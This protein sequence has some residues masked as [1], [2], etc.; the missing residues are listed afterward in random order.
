MREEY[1]RKEGGNEREMW[2]GRMKKDHKTDGMERNRN[3]K[4]KQTK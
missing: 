1:K 4:I 2:A 3:C